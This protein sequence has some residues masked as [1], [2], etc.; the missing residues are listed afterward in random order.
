[1]IKRKSPLK[2]TPLK[3]NQ[4]PLPKKRSKPPRGPFRDPE[5]IAW[6]RLW[7]CIACLRHA[8]PGLFWN[9]FKALLGSLARDVAE[10]EAVWVELAGCGRTEA[11]HVGARGLDQKCDDRDVLPLGS[12]HHRTGPEAHH[13]IGRAFWSRHALTQSLGRTMYALYLENKK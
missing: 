2:R 1:V 9:E 12:K 13:V 5:F 6:V 3:R 7:P 10:R 11:A 4:K 8:Y